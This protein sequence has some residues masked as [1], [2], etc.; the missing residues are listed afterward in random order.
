MAE[1]ACAVALHTWP[2]VRHGLAGA[3]QRKIWL[4][5]VAD[6]RHPVIWLTLIW[7]SCCR[8]SLFNLPPAVPLPRRCH[9]AR[10]SLIKRPAL[11]SCYKL[12]PVFL[13]RSS[14]RRAASAL[15]GRHVQKVRCPLHFGGSA[16]SRCPSASSEHGSRVWYV[17]SPLCSLSPAFALAHNRPFAN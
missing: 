6:V 16:R 14:L 8:R 12:S 11:Q 3:A 15:P 2:C 13:V 7:C 10:P 17:Q 5:C 4:R 1:T 9:R